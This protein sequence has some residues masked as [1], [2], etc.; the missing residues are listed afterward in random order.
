VLALGRE[1][2]FQS[3]M[4]TTVLVA[5]GISTEYKRDAVEAESNVRDV[6]LGA[7]ICMNEA[8]SIKCPALYCGV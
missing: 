5:Y 6:R 4:T 1:F 8:D 2:G 7:V 3:N